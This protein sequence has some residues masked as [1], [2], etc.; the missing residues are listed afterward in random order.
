MVR[1]WPFLWD[2]VELAE[3]CIFPEFDTIPLPLKIKKRKGKSGR[4]TRRITRI[5]R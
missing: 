2:K 5:D 4:D 3:L 1:K